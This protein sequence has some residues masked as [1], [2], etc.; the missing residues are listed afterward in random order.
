[1]VIGSRNIILFIF[2]LT[3]FHSLSYASDCEEILEKLSKKNSEIVSITVDFIQEK[4]ICIVEDT[5]VSRG[6]LSFKA[7]DKFRWETSSPERSIITCDGTTVR[8]YYSEID[9]LDEATQTS[10]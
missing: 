1:M 6:K 3:G 4:Y 10:A 7:P 8:I 9:E 5:L 2:L